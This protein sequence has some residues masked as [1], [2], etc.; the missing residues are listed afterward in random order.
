MRLREISYEHRC[1][2]VHSVVVLNDEGPTDQQYEPSSNINYSEVPKVMQSQLFLNSK[3]GLHNHTNLEVDDVNDYAPCVLD[4]DIEKGMAESLKSNVETVATLTSDDSLQKALH[5]DICLHIGGKFMQL[6]MNHGIELPKFT[7]R[8][9]V[10]D[11]ASSRSRKYKRSQSFN[12]RRI[13]LLFSVMSS[14]GTIILI[15][16]TLRVRLVSDGS[17][18]V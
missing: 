11:A 10:Y 18:N 6:L 14:M 5:R 8:E 4:V 13:L 12:S 16:L 7:S 15:Y 9:R 17:G 2:N 3:P 1:Q